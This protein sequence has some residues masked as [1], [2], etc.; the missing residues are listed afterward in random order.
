M[1]L[2]GKIVSEKIKKDLLNEINEMEVKPTLSVI[3]LG[4]SKESLSYI[5]MKRRMCESLGIKF[6][7]QHFDEKVEECIVLKEIQTLNE[8]KNVDGILIQ[9]PLPVHFNKDKLLQ[10]ISYKK[11]VDGF[12]TINAGKLFQ[13]RDINIIPCT[14][15][16]CIDMI[17]YYDINVEGLTITIIG[18]SNLVGLPL[19]MLLL[20]RGA[21]ISLCNINTKDIK[22]HTIESDMII[23]CC[24]VANMV[25]SDWIKQGV[26]IIDIGINHIEDKLVGDVD[27]ADVYEKCSY[28]TPVPGGVGPMTVISLMK[29]LVKLTKNNL[30][31]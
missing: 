2:D 13:N 3:L 24:G 9:L 29:N 27:F 10:E 26:I 17:D 14:P 30:N 16:G 18:T 6:I 22:L 25:K 8:D 28:I 12:H 5:N 15:Q 23:T 1:I 20:Q 21:T 7:L 11:D 19:S 4:H 31:I